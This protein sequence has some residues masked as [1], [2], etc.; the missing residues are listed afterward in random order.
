MAMQREYQLTCES[1]SQITTV[2]LHENRFVEDY[3]GPMLLTGDERFFSVWR[4]VCCECW[5]R[6]TYLSS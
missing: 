1:F 6:C 2:F 3:I 5:C 4:N